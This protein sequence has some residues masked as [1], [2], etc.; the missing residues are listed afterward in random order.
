VYRTAVRTPIEHA[1]LG[2]S[3]ALNILGIAGIAEDALKW[4]SFLTNL[5]YYYRRYITELIYNFFSLIWP[6][7]LWFPL[8]YAVSDL[9][10][11]TAGFFA[12]ANFYT[13]QT[14]GTSVIDRVSKTHCNK[15]GFVA[16]NA[17]LVASVAG[18]YILGPLVYLRALATGPT[19]IHR[20][21]GFVF[22][23]AQIVRYYFTLLIG[24]GLLIFILSQFGV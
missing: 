12:A 2:L 17:C 8:P 1:W 22:C 20:V 11:L 5:L 14:E 6:D 3:I 16:R 15:G 13:M 19:R 18:L 7:F 23:P 9:L 10:I 4:K 21:L 24:A